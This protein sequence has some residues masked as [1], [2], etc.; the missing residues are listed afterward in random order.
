MDIPAAQVAYKSILDVVKQKELSFTQDDEKLS[1]KLHF[2]TDSLTVEIFLSVDK[3]RNLIRL[4]SP[5]SFRFSET[6][7]PDAIFAITAVNNYLPNGCFDFNTADRRI[8]FKI[9]N[10]YSVH[11]DGTAIFGAKTIN[12]K[13]IT[14]MLDVA[15]SYITAFGMPFFSLSTNAITLP[16]FL[17]KLKTLVGA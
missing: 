12:Q 15:A 6:K 11:D 3:E 5:L 16:M 14:Y 8:I 9:Y 7:S 13:N 2:W 10:A 4:S 1:V 17:E